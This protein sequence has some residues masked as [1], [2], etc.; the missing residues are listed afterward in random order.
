M[1]T[2]AHRTMIAEF[3]TTLGAAIA[4]TISKSQAVGRM[5]EFQAVFAQLID[6][7]RT[8]EGC[9][10]YFR[11]PAGFAQALRELAAREHQ[12]CP[13]VT[14][15]LFLEGERL[16]WETI[17]PKEAQGV[18]DVFYGLPQSLQRDDLS[19]LKQAAES[20]GVQLIG[21]GMAAK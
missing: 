11:N 8:V 17:G 9:R 7:E 21:E 18:I 3:R 20:A 1:S 10:W 12:C 13:F 2:D 6:G 5:A 15:T 14:F 4:C 19:T 16:V